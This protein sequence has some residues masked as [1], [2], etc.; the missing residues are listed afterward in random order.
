MIEIQDSV[1]RQLVAT[2]TDIIALPGAGNIGVRNCHNEPDQRLQTAYSYL[3]V[4][5]VGGDRI[6]AECT[7]LP[8][9]GMQT[10]S[11]HRN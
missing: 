4:D 2:G 6:S 9:R 7:A 1:E 3:L 11:F 8:G 5:T 10:A